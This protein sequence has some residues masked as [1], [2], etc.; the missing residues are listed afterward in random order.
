MFSIGPSHFTSN[1][2]NAVLS[3]SV[4]FCF[5]LLDAKSLSYFSDANA[6]AH[7][8][9][10]LTVITAFMDGNNYFVA[11]LEDIE[12]ANAGLVLIWAKTIVFSGLRVSPVKCVV[13]VRGKYTNASGKVQTDLS[14]PRAHIF[15]CDNKG[16]PF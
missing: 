13:P 14:G 2:E 3:E 12:P 15:L 9:R 1:E 4:C 8:F 11:S 5:G 16:L 6:V 10:A 7:R